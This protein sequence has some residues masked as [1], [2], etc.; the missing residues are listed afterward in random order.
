MALLREQGS[1][2]SAHGP[3]HARRPEFLKI[4]ISKYK[5]DEDDSLLRW[6]VELDDAIA[7]RHIEGDKMQVTFAL[8]NLTGRAKVWALVLKLQDSHTFGSLNVLKSWLREISEP[9]SAESRARSALLRLKQRKR[10]VHGYAQ[11]LRHLA[12]CA[13]E[14][15]VDGYTLIDTFLQ[16]LADGPVRT[17]MFREEFHTLDQAIAYAEQEDYSLRQSRA[18]STSCSPPRRQENVDPEPMDLCYVESEVPR[19]QNHKGSTR[20]KRCQKIGHYFYE[21]GVPSDTVLPKAGRDDRRW[22]NRSPR[23]GS[24]AA[25]KA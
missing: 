5:G 11:H 1:L 14:H 2:Q 12:S 18:T 21:C 7:A 15:P 24:E 3:T 9:P 4:D 17:Y 16:G 22:I 23:R 13:T 20:C 25:E 8:S 6:F 10:D 19:T